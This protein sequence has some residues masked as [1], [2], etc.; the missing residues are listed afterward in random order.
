[1]KKIVIGIA[2]EMASGKDTIA[3]YIVKK[4]GGLMLGFSMPL[5]AVLK[6]LEQEESRTNMQELSTWAREKFGQ[7]L[8]AKIIAKRVKTSPSEVIAIQGVRRL[9]DIKYLKE[10]PE[11][12]LIYVEADVEKRLER[13]RARKQ[14]PDDA[15]K[16]MEQFQKELGQES[17]QQIK[18]L[19][20]HADHMIDN[21]GT[22][23]E[24]YSRVDG[25]VD[26]D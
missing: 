8:L 14:N 15:S 13:I 5:R 12:K 4:H 3:E 23:D 1:M 24:L 9:P 19:R 7:D 26:A 16:T 21:N 2:G 11:F 22:K 20:E 17:E 18:G 10:V 6:E 25:I